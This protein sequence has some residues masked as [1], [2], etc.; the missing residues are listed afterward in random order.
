MRWSS[1]YWPVGLA[2]VAMTALVLG[3]VLLG[4]WWAAGGEPDLG[5]TTKRPGDPGT[6]ADNPRPGEGDRCVPFE[7]E[8]TWPEL[9]YVDCDSQ[10]AYWIVYASLDDAGFEVDEHGELYDYTP[11]YELC[12]EDY[13]ENLPGQTWHESA[14][15]RNDGT[16]DQFYC[17]RAIPEP[18]EEGRLPVL[19]TVGDCF[20]EDELWTVPCDHPDA[21]GAVTDVIITPRGPVLSDDDVRVLA[22]F[23]EG[24]WYLEIEGIEGGTSYLLCFD[25]V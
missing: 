15:V 10:E 5:I 25:P 23:C 8:Y 17:Y 24:G 22:D 13:G 16:V 4:A 18:D 7:P 21:T 19:P 2:V 11:V 1:K 12:G 14:Q 9:D 6:E 3:S 20:N